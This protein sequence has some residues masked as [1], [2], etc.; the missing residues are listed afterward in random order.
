MLYAVAKDISARLGD[1]GFALLV[2]DFEN[3]EISNYVSNAYRADVIVALREAAD[4]VE[5][6]DRGGSTRH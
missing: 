3:P 1:I 4:R 6:I 2:F 5:G